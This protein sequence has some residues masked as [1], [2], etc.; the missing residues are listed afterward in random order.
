[1]SVIETKIFIAL[2]YYTVAG[3]LTLADFSLV[4]TKI[5]STTTELQ[6]YFICEGKGSGS[7]CDKSQVQQILTPWLDLTTYAL[8]GL[9]P[10]VNLIF[11]ISWKDVKRSLQEKWRKMIALL[12]EKS[13]TDVERHGSL[14][15]TDE[16]F[17]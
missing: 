9:F 15:G 17:H 11:I 1:M 2:T 13:S 5:D 4:A 7:P 14:D 6:K 12:K 3:A 10:V 8:S 16:Q